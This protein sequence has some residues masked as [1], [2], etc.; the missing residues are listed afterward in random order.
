MYG[1]EGTIYEGSKFVIEFKI[2][3]EYPFRPPK[4]LFLTRVYHPNINENGEVSIDI[5]NKP[6][7][8]WSP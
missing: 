4:T 3:S 2:P 7:Q 8:H 5:L 6:T 1:P